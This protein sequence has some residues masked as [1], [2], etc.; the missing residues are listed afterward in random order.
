MPDWWEKY[1]ATH[2]RDWS[3]QPDYLWVALGANDHNIEPDRLQKV[4]QRWLTSAR[5]VFPTAE[6][7][8]VVPFHGENR[9]PVTSAVAQQADARIHGVDLG[10]EIQS[11]LPFV[12]GRVTWLTADGL[13]LRAMYQGLV[14]TGLA[15]S[16]A[17]GTGSRATAEIPMI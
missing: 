12:P 16:I 2:S 17:G 15:P 6:I 4:I 11:A 13:H 9:A 3:L 10:T 8:V 7:F 1:D 5:R 14:A